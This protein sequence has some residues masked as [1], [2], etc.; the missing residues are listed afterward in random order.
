MDMKVPRKTP[1]GH[2]K[3]IRPRIK[4]TRA[5]PPHISDGISYL[6]NTRVLGGGAI[7]RRNNK[8]KENGGNKAVNGYWSERGNR[9]Q[10][11]KK[12]YKRQKSRH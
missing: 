11:K 7:R 8:R 3:C 1:Q 4:Y 12:N 9:C 5:S 10:P 2:G 6:A